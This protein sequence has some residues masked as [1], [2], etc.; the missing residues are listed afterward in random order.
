ML[1]M[2]LREGY[3]RQN[4]FLSIPQVGRAISYLRQLFIVRRPLAGIPQVASLPPASSPL[5][6][7]YLRGILLLLGYLITGAK[8][9]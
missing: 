5:L 2:H 8:G 7:T 3:L 6:P 9:Y 4:F 1:P